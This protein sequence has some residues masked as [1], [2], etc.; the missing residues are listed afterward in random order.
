MCADFTNGYSISVVS[1]SADAT[2][3]GLV[4]ITA[5]NQLE[6]GTVATTDSVTYPAGTH[7]FEITVTEQVTFR[8]V[9]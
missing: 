4:S 9:S 1:S 6:I 8:V 5:D 2:I 3:L 7:E